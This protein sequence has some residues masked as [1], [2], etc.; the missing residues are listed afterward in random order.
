MQPGLRASRAEPGSVGP[1][2]TSETW[3]LEAKH[4]DLPLERSVRGVKE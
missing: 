2:E 4:K 1:G 3:T